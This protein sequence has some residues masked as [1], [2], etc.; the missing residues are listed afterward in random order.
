M[1]LDPNTAATLAYGFLLGFQRPV[2]A[3][4]TNAHVEGGE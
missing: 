4:T 3:P 2:E 1:A